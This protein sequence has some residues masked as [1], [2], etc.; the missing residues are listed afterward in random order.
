MTTVKNPTNSVTE[1]LRNSGVLRALVG[2]AMVV[3]IFQLANPVFLSAFNITNLL[4]QVAAVGMISIGVVFVLMLAEI[5]LTV[6]VVSGVS[7]AV[8]ALTAFVFGFP[9]LLAIGVGLLCGLLI[10]LLQGLI[11][12]KS[13]APSFIV[14]LCGLLAWQGVLLWL[15]GNDGTVNITDPVILAVTGT[16]FKGA[17]GWVL[18]AALIS[19]LLAVAVVRYVRGGARRLRRSTTLV[20]AAVSIAVVGSILMADRGVPLPVLLLILAATFMQFVLQRTTFGR[21][22]FAVGGNREAARRAGIS[23][24]RVTL[25]V[26]AISGTMAALGG[27]LAASRLQAVSTSSGGSLLL[28]L[29]IAGP[30]IAGTSLFGGK[31]TV[32][33]AVVGAVLIGAISNGMDLLAFPPALKA[34]VTGLVLLAAVLIDAAPLRVSRKGR[35]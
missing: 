32:W 10:G 13:G 22:V 34:I 20:A 16:Y 35:R 24:E 30:V 9:G 28:L 27:V 14:T 12:T 21:H 33:S 8:M 29:A 26:F 31:G 7:S 18:L 5:D 23:I 3:V 2:L 19:S 25:A 11:I 4:L 1:A 17:A 15:I 6:G